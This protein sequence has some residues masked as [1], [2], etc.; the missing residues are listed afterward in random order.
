MD[1]FILEDVNELIRSKKGDSSRLIRIKEACESNEIVSLSDRKYIERLSSQYLHQPEPKK[2]K[3]Q[4]QPKFIPIEESDISSKNIANFTINQTPPIEKPKL[5]E[6]QGGFEEKT[7]SKILNF[8]PK[9]KVI[10]S[11]ASIALAIILIGVVAIGNDGIQFQDSSDNIKTGALP[12]FSLEIDRTSY[13]TSDII[14]ISG[15][16]SSLSRGTLRLF[17][18]NENN[19]LIWAEN[20]NLKNNGEFSTLLIAGGQGWENDGKYFLYVEYNEFSSSIS[21][22]FNA[23]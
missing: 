5:F 21:F 20:L 18:E 7:G 9:K 1:S 14:S 11:I 2:P 16:M 17:I 10:F 22:D 12:D 8:N 6:E 4:D 19:E 15:K 13:E 3:N 23:K